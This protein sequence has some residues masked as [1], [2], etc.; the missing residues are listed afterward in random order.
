MNLQSDLSTASKSEEREA[1]NQQEAP[2]VEN[3]SSSIR[4][5]EETALLIKSYTNRPEAV[6]WTPGVVGIGQNIHYSRFVLRTSDWLAVCERNEGELVANRVCSIRCSHFFARVISMNILALS[7]YFVRRVLYRIYTSCLR[8]LG[9]P[10]RIPQ[11][12][13]KSQAV[14]IE[15]VPGVADVLDVEGFDLT[16]AGRQHL[17]FWIYIR[18]TTTAYKEHTIGLLG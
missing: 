7:H 1:Q 4:A 9:D 2:E 16:V 18:R 17:G 15:V 13:T 12:P 3:F 10:D 6:R 11:A 8:M 14:G 5:H